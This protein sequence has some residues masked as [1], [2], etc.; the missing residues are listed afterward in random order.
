MI[1]RTKENDKTLSIALDTFRHNGNMRLFGQALDRN[2]KLLI[3]DWVHDLNLL[4]V[5]G[6][7]RVDDTLKILDDICAKNDAL[8]YVISDESHIAIHIIGWTVTVFCE[9]LWIAKYARYYICESPT[10]SK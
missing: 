2:R 6:R 8:L 9:R 7:D 10:N 1:P 4:M 3:P 5:R